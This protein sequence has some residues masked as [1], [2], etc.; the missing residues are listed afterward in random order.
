MYPAYVRINTPPVIGTDATLYGFYQG[1]HLADAPSTRA[2]DQ[3]VDATV[4]VPADERAFHSVAG[5]ASA[6]RSSSWTTLWIL[7]TSRPRTDCKAGV[8]R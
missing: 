3:A 6:N 1:P 8:R 4:T 7:L 5:R 2:G